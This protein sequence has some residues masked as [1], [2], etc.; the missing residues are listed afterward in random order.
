[1]RDA[2]LGVAQAHDGLLAAR[3]ENDDVGRAFARGGRE[4]RPEAF[5]DLDD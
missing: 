5:P 3:L 1:M 2:T 4:K